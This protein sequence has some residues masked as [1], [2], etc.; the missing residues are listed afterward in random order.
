MIG[1]GRDV[2]ELLDLLCNAD[3]R[4][5]TITGPGGVGKTRLA[6]EAAS[7]AADE[8][9]DGTG[10]VSLAPVRDP[11]LVLPVI[12]AVARSGTLQRRFPADVIQRP[13]GSEAAARA[14]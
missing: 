6:L 5:V 3:V 4:L 1:R 8:F 12:A 13:A 9:V 11:A 2:E 14:R 10:F 7:L